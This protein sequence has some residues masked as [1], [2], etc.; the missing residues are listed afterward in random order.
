MVKRFPSNAGAQSRSLVSELRSYMPRSRAKRLKL[1]KKISAFNYE[2]EPVRE[3]IEGLNAFIQ[4]R[5]MA[6]PKCPGCS[7]L[8]WTRPSEGKGW[9]IRWP[10]ETKW[11]HFPQVPFTCC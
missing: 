4:G 9:G 2:A 7:L 1:K 3:R 10:G 8:L 11:T 5:G 6:C